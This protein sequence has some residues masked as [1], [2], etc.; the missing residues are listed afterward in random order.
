M[1]IAPATI[2]KDYPMTAPSYAQ[3]RRDLAVKI[4][5]GRKPVDTK[6]EQKAAP[7]KLG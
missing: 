1:R 3:M 5:L 7:K 2:C 4:G 6:A